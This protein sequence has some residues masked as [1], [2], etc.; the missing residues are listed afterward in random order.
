[1]A[2]MLMFRGKDGGITRLGASYGSYDKSTALYPLNWFVLD[3]N[4]PFTSDVRTM[5]CA[6][7]T[8]TEGL[9][10]VQSNQT[11]EYWVKNDTVVNKTLVTAWN[12][13]KYTLATRYWAEVD[14]G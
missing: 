10:V 9:W 11:L 14:S 12:K 4:M 3:E 5:E 13:S 8:G 2:V 6:Y 7:D 1:V